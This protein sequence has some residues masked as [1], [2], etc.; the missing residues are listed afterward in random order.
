MVKRGASREVSGSIS[1]CPV[2]PGD[3]LQLNARSLNRRGVQVCDIHARLNVVE[4][5]ADA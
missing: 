4:Q 2:R 3:I 1:I 5:L